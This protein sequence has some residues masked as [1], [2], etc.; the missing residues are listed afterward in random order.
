MQVGRTLCQW[1]LQETHTTVSLDIGLLR[2]LYGK[3]RTESENQT[4]K[5]CFIC[6]RDPLEF[7][8]HTFLMNTFSTL[9]LSS[10]IRNVQ[11]SLINHDSERTNF[12]S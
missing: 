2:T 5:N 8:S 7:M 3:G 11:E 1:N 9:A 12:I 10:K 4:K 6:F